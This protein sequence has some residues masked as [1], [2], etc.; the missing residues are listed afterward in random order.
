MGQKAGITTSSART[1]YPKAKKK[2]I[3]LQ[4]ASE[5][6]G[7]EDTP[8]PVKKK[9]TPK[10]AARPAKKRK[11]SEQPEAQI[12]SEIADPIEGAIAGP[13]TD[14]TDAAEPVAGE[15]EH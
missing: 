4:A 1:M 12:K 9:A 15:E 7:G 3:K 10:K 11:V 6:E 5:S 14:E 2:L 13:E 8:T